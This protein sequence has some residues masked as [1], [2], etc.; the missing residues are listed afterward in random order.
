MNSSEG[1][2]AGWRRCLLVTTS[3]QPPRSLNNGGDAIVG[4]VV[5]RGRDYQ[6]GD[7]EGTGIVC[8]FPKVEN[9][10]VRS[11]PSTVVET[12]YMNLRLTLTCI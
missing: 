5:C 3:V 4:M 8:V 2:P 11:N 1:R 10:S 9:A 12:I 6:A 7:W